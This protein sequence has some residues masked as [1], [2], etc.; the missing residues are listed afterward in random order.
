M[1][2]VDHC[3]SLVADTSKARVQSSP[4]GVAGQRRATP[5]A[6]ANDGGQ[7]LYQFYMDQGPRVSGEY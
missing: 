3:T 6:D 1:H 5:A 7:E 2:L 4:G